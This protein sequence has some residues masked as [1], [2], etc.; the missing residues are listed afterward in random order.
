MFKRGKNVA[1]IGGDDFVGLDELDDQGKK[2]ESQRKTAANGGIEFKNLSS[3]AVAG[4]KKHEE[5][6][7]KES[8]PAERPRFFGKAKIGGGGAEAKQMTGTN[9]TYDFGVKFAG[10]NKDKPNDTDGNKGK[11]ERKDAIPD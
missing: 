2:K 4:G 7:E 5:E 3:T 9:I 6:K 11:S 10:Q 1:G 8:K